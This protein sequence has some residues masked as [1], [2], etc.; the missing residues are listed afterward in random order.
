VACQPV[1]MYHPASLEA[2]GGREPD[3]LTFVVC[4][5]GTQGARSIRELGVV[6]D[7]F[8]VRSMCCE[9]LTVEANYDAT[10][11][12]EDPSYS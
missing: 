7:V 9:E 3:C 10:R 4:G 6:M 12:A 11:P 1:R 2:A 5:V 8:G